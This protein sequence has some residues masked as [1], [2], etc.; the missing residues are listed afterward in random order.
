M[1]NVGFGDDVRV[2]LNGDDVEVSHP[3]SIFKFVLSK[4]NDS[5]LRYT[6]YPT[7]STP[8]HLD[9]YTKTNVYVASLCVYFEDTPVLDQV[10]ALSMFIK[11]GDEEHILKTANWSRVNAEIKDDIINLH[12]Y[13]RAKL[14]R[15]WR[16]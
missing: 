3:E 6:T 2:F 15:V 4:K 16:P 5:L 14:G 10:L 8:Y 13:L 1:D 7:R 12:P 11:T 9:L